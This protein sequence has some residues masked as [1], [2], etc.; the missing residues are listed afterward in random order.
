MPMASISGEATQKLA[1]CCCRRTMPSEKRDLYACVF[2]FDHT[3]IC[4]LSRGTK[5]DNGSR[6]SL[7]F[8]CTNI[9]SRLQHTKIKLFFVLDYVFIVI[10][11]IKSLPR[12]IFLVV[13]CYFI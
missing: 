6:S 7:F 8:A 5:P 13:S 10:Y 9:K 4:T 2:F 11:I 3:H 1:K 12:K